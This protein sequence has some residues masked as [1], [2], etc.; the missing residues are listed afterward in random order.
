[1]ESGRQWRFFWWLIAVALLL[2]ACNSPIN[3]LPASKGEVSSLD[4]GT[5]KWRYD[6][7]TDSGGNQ[8]SV[9]SSAAI[10]DDGT[11]YVVAGSG[12]NNRLYAINP[13]SSLKWGAGLSP[14]MNLTTPVIGPD[15]TIYVG[16]GYVQNFVYHGRLYA[17]NP[18]GSSRWI[19]QHGAFLQLDAYVTSSPAI[20]ADGTV[21]VGLLESWR[22]QLVALDPDDATVKWVRETSSGIKTSPAIAPDGVIYVAADS[23][24][25][26]VSSDG[27][28]EWQYDSDLQFSSHSPAIGSDGAIFIGTVAAFDSTGLSLG[29][30]KLYAIN[31]DGSVRWVSNIQ[32]RE[33]SV[34]VNDLQTPTVGADGTVYVQTSDQMLHAINPDGSFAWHYEFFPYPTNRW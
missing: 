25:Y 20:G 19:T 5:V 27:T 6:F 31:P 30:S 32:L 2:A 18:D 29:Y 24:L 16:A 8:I 1:M 21:Y 11:V 12:Y 3:Q 14:N 17:F 33:G 13:D 26:A 9:G 34:S 7:G 22:G 15:G 10:G 23:Q 4:V 28:L